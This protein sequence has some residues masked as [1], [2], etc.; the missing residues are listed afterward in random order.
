LADVT[1]KMPNQQGDI[2]GDIFLYNPVKI[3]NHFLLMFNL[4]DNYIN[5]FKWELERFKAVF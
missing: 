3:S 5:G 4:D 2:F 1:G